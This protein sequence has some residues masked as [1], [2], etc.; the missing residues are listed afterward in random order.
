MNY[1]SSRGADVKF[2]SAQAIKQGIAPD[3]GLF[4]PEMIPSLTENDLSALLGKSYVEI[5]AYV[6]SLYLADYSKSELLDYCASA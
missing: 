6:L 2:T 3:G 4:V 5:A 1:I